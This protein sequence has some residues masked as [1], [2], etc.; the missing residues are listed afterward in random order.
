MQYILDAKKMKSLDE[1][2]IQNIGIPAMVLIER[3]ALSIFN[4]V[5]R[6]INNQDTILVICGTGNNGGDGIAAARLLKEE[7][8][9]V[10][11]LLIGDESHVSEQTK[12]QLSIA[13]YLGVNILNN[14]KVSA[15]N[16]IVDAIFGIGLSKAVEGIYEAIINEINESKN[17]VFSVDIPSGI[18]AED[19]QIMNVAVKADYTITFGYNKIGLVLYP[20][21]EYAG[22]VL[23]EDIG[24]PKIALDS[25]KPDTFIYTKSDLDRLPKRRE[26]SNKGTYGRVLI[27]AGSKNMSGACYMAAKAAYRAGA[28]LVK[29]LTV[30]EN[31]SI[32]QTLLPEAI[33]STYDSVDLD[34]QTK[35]NLIIRDINQASAIV[36]GPGMGI[37]RD[38]NQLIDLVLTYAKVPV[39][40]DADAITMIAERKDYVTQYSGTTNYNDINLPRDIIITPHLKEMSRLLGCET[41]QISE[42]I[43]ESAR[44]ATESKEYIL[45]LKDARTIVS[46]GTHFYINCSGNNGM[47]TAGVGDA[48]TGI[49]AAFVAQGMKSYDATCLGVYVHGLAGDAVAMKKGAYS[50]MATDLIEALPAILSFNV[51]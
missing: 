24:F 4:Q 9:V 50:L 18:R 14:A 34:N 41:R 6:K 3:A 49:I 38:S 43:L 31:R 26:Y 2:A 8:Y 47:A 51:N 39:V 30:S 19:G 12:L 20:G 10:S 36:I 32:L 7:G 46:N 44:T 28:G 29:V 37:S 33:L 17:T 15:Y 5:K 42:K 16:V 48:L 25:V 35:I 1:Y 22:E 45:A 27:I 23:V 13:K 21:C 11:V 40:V